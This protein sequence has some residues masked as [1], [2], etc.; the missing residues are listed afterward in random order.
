MCSANVHTVVISAVWC[1]FVCAG[2][3][4]ATNLR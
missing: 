3:W 4:K 2:W 1:M